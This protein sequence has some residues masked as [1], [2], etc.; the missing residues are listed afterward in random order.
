MRI[1]SFKGRNFRCFESIEFEPAT[2]VNVV[3]GDNATGKTSILE[4][5]YLLG[6]GR[7]FRNGKPRELIKQ[8]AQH[9]ALH[10]RLQSSGELS[11]RI[12]IAGNNNA[13][14]YKL[15][16]RNRTTRFDL[17]TTLPL[18]LI[19]PDL[20]RL[21]E[22]GPRHRRHFLDWGVFHVEH[23]FFMAWRQYHRILRQRNRALKSGL[24]NNQVVVWDGEMAR[25]ADVMDRCRRKYVDRLR[26]HMSAR[27]LRLLGG[28]MPHMAYRSGWRDNDFSAT[29]QASLEQDRKAGFTRYGPHRG[30]LQFEVD[31]V[32]ARAHV[33][34]GQQKLLA[35]ALL[36]TQARILQQEMNIKPVLLF[37]DP[38]AELGPDFLQGLIAEVQSLDCQVFMTFLDPQVAVSQCDNASVFHVEHGCVTALQ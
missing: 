2:G 27:V 26:E 13:L 37:D 3:S 30:D 12:G 18:Q 23:H 36:L 8:G 15:D 20:H 34:R 38:A 6:R 9:F 29:L 19:D 31:G 14:R 4:A 35:A 33:S 25:A 22:K 17:A 11:H 28:Q 1:T 5:L 24:P 32:Q 21:L 10:G 7:P 16:D